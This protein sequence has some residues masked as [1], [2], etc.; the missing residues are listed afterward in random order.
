M[1]NDNRFMKSDTWECPLCGATL[2][3]HV[4]VV[5]P[6]VCYNRNSHSS[7]VVEMQLLNGNELKGSK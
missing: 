4:N 3:V 1:E 7:K 2:T 6:P 5:E